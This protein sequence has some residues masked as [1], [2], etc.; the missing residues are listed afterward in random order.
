MIFIANKSLLLIWIAKI[1]DNL[2]LGRFGERVNLAKNDGVDHATC[3]FLLDGGIKK[4]GPS[5][6]AEDNCVEAVERMSYNIVIES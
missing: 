6:I 5:Y 1:F 2:C 4:E 3:N